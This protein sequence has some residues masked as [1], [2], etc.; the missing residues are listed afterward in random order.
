MTA[1]LQSVDLT[2]PILYALVPFAGLAVIHVLFVVVTLPRRVRQLR[3]RVEELEGR[4]D[5]L[6]ADDV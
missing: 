4:I 5:E 1:A 2:T 3:S 6:E